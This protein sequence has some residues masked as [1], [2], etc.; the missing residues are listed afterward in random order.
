MAEVARLLSVKVKTAQRRDREGTH[1]K[2]SPGHGPLGFRQ[3]LTMLKYQGA[4]D[5][6]R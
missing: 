5:G 2:G 4:R 3:F 6:T 1:E